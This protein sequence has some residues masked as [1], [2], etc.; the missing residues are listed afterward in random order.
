MGWVGGIVFLLR[1]ASVA[2]SEVCV[3][4]KTSHLMMVWCGSLHDVQMLE[5]SQRCLG[6]VVSNSRHE[7]QV[8]VSCRK[9]STLHCRRCV[10]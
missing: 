1:Y 10:T 2:G 6:F 5:V 9:I 3:S 7:M 4:G 8:A